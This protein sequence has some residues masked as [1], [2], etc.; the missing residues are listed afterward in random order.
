MCLALPQFFVGAK[1][2]VSKESFSK[3][4]IAFTDLRQPCIDMV[5]SAAILGN[6]GYTIGPP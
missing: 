4:G 1:R 3:K 5:F 6:S 2:L